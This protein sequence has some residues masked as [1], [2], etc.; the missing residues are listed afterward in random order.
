M[1]RIV[2]IKVLPAAMTKDAA[3]VARFEREVTAAARL[4]HPNIV[5]AHDADEAGGVH[6]LVMQYVDGA[7]LAALVKQDGPF[8]T[9]KATNYIL[10][11][12][13]GLEYAHREGVIHRDI[14]PANLLVDKHVVVKVLD[15][16][17]ARLDSNDAAVQAELTTTGTVMGTMDY[18]APEQ[19]ADTRH[20]DARADVYSLGCTLYFLLAGV[21]PYRGESLMSKLVAHR[22]HPI[23]SLRDIKPDASQ[24][25]DAVFR[26]MVA[27]QVEAR[28]QSMSEVIA[29][30]EKCSRGADEALSVQRPLAS[31][32]DSEVLTFLRDIDTAPAPHAQRASKT[33]KPTGQPLR[34]DGKKILLAAAGGALLAAIL[35]SSAAIMLKPGEGTIVVDVNPS[36]AVVR[37]LS[38]KGAVEASGRAGPGGVSLS[39]EPGK[40]RLRVEKDGFAVFAKDF[41]IAAGSTQTIKAKLTRHVESIDRSLAQWVLGKGGRVVVEVDGRKM[42]VARAAD[43]PG[44]V[45]RL[46]GAALT[47]LPVADSDLLHFKGM[48]WLRDI[49][50]AGDK[51]ITDAGLQSLQWVPELQSLDL[52]GTS[53]T[54]AGVAA[55]QKSLP[56]CAIAGY[57]DA[58]RRAA[59]WVL[60][61]GGDVTVEVGGAEIWVKAIG[62]LP[63]GGTAVTQIALDGAFVA[64]KD[65]TN[66]LGLRGLKRLTFQKCAGITDE[67]LENL[68]GLTTLTS[69][70]LPTSGEN[71]TDAGLDHL[72]GLKALQALDLGDARITERSLPVLVG[73]KELETLRLPVKTALNGPVLVALKDLPHL[74]ELRLPPLDSP[75]SYAPLAEFELLTILSLSGSTFDDSLFDYV[76]QM[77]NL[78]KLVFSHSQSVTGAGV[79]KLQNCPKLNVLQF[80]YCAAFPEGILVSLQSVKNLKSLSLLNTNISDENL[81]QLF[82]MTNLAT[83]T[84][85]GTP[86][87]KEGV[88][89]LQK[90]LPN[91]KIVWPV[92]GQIFGE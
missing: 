51:S 39:I 33:A 10:Q 40:H 22:E 75:A 55:L 66:L 38:E 62:E 12:A 81:W 29:D 54:T 77:K 50:L 37:V 3:A 69:L 73:F 49:S 28:Y 27:K 18:M 78:T 6:F 42:L 8:S 5:T 15:M 88:A 45:F 26:R 31:Q 9:A 1:H 79:L 46:T 71:I 60:G 4:E 91:C 59:L 43:L 74:S 64:D 13:R 65:L 92:R 86:T 90:A 56:K 41:E 67:G 61:K 84:L 68:A 52:R 36:E 20:A 57:V 89:A 7:D 53:V 21:P 82:P 19:A 11:A 44:G 72:S 47:N 30:L 2:A 32:P 63:Q 80:G 87:T 70:N 85:T 25:L 35:V 76:V 48:P 83:V 16:G 34:R 58:D 14:K 24:R 23:P 17:L